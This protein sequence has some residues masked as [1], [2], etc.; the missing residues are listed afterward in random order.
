MYIQEKVLSE[1]RLIEMCVKG[2]LVAASEPGASAAQWAEK[3]EAETNIIREQFRKTQKFMYT[4]I[5]TF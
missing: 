5:R 3:N 4:S 2:S 1:S